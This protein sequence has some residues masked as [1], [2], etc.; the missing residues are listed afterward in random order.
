MK[1]EELKYLKDN[2]LNLL[3]LKDDLL[4]TKE[5]IEILENHSVVKSYLELVDFLKKN[6]QIENKSNEELM[7]DF[8]EKTMLFEDFD[9]TN[10]IYIYMGSFQS[11]DD[12]SQ[13]SGV[14]CYES[15]NAKYRAYLNLESSSGFS[16]QKAVAVPL[17]EEEN[18]KKNHTVIYTGDL[19]AP[20]KY[21]QRFSLIKKEF[22]KVSILESQQM[23]RKR[24]LSMDSSLKN[25]IQ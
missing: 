10:N 2:F 19:L 5:K 12:V 9:D 6:K 15:P 18:F 17:I 14:E 11:I 3:K 22:L 20:N 24:V 23:A 8:L 21:L 7:K 4:K 1:D 13:G 16:Y 25:K